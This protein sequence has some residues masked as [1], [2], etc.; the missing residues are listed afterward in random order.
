MFLLHYYVFLKFFD[1]SRFPP[2]KPF[3]VFSHKE[4]YKE[5]HVYTYI[6][7]CIIQGE[8]CDFSL[9]YCYSDWFCKGHF[10]LTSRLDYVCV[11][12]TIW[13]FPQQK[14]KALVEY[15][16]SLNKTGTYVNTSLL[17]KRPFFPLCES[18]NSW[19]IALHSFSTVWRKENVV[20]HQIK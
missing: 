6:L 12:F 9:L 17:F 11:V 10:L 8:L 1:N 4:K 14:W 20:K 16:E 3:N 15:P 13:E 18:F 5:I 7:L 2:L 19:S